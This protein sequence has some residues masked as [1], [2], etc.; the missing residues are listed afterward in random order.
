MSGGI[1]TCQNP[2]CRQTATLLEDGYC[3]DDCR[4]E[5]TGCLVPGCECLG[6]DDAVSRCRDCERYAGDVV[7]GRCPDCRSAAQPTASTG[8]RP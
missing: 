5:A 1:G 6:A 4:L 2:S 3:S 7:A 8:I